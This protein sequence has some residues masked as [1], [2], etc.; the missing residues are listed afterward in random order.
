[1]FR[2]SVSEACIP[3]AHKVL[4]F[5]LVVLRDHTNRVCGVAT[6]VYRREQGLQWF[7]QK[8]DCEDDGERFGEAISKT[9][10]RIGNARGLFTELPDRDFGPCEDI[11]ARAPTKTRKKRELLDTLVK[12]LESSMGVCISISIKLLHFICCF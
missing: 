3:L 8:L 7:G 6:T 2:P 1:M 9:H 12:I 11:I 10:L 5:W 4:I